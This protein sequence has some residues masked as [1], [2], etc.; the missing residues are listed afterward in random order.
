MISE[1]DILDLLPI[2]RSTL[3][4]W[5]ADGEF[6]KPIHI[7]KELERPGTPQTLPAGR[8]SGKRPPVNL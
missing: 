1:K 7:G 3:Q 8:N 4:H 6:P 5:I 2:A